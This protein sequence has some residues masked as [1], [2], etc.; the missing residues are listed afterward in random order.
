MISE[1]YTE[2]FALFA[3]FITADP[4]FKEDHGA[5]EPTWYWP[6][7]STQEPARCLSLLVLRSHSFKAQGREG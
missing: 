5:A 3:L 2:D 4:G 7:G 1:H 6:Q